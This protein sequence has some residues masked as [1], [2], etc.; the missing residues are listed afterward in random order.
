VVRLQSGCGLRRDVAYYR[1][2]D[3]ALTALA[4]AITPAAQRAA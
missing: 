3:D 4:T 2:V 1:I